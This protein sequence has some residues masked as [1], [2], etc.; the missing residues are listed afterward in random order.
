MVGSLLGQEPQNPVQ[1][2][3]ARGRLTGTLSSRALLTQS[4]TRTILEDMLWGVTSETLEMGDQGLHAW[5]S[6]HTGTLRPTGCRRHPA[7]TLRREYQESLCSS[8]AAAEAWKIGSYLCAGGGVQSPGGQAHGHSEDCHWAPV[9]EP[10]FRI[11]I[12]MQIQGNGK[13]EFFAQNLSS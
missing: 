3:T 1:A 8:C 12:L 11:K 13:A 7:A 5:S 10:R 9:R 2:R 6:L 4:E